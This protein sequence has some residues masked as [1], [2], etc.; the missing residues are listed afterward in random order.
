MNALQKLIDENFIV[1]T[2]PKI[3]TNIDKKGKE[4]KQPINMPKWK[5]ITKD[6]YLNYCNMSHQ[7][8]AIITGKISNLTILDFDDINEYNRLIKEYPE[9][10]TY[11]TIK[12]NKGVHMYFNYTDKLETTT[13]ALKS[14]NYVD[15]RNDDGVIFC[16][17][18]SYTLKNG[19]VCKYEDLGGNMLDVPD[20]LINDAKINIPSSPTSVTQLHTPRPIIE[21]KSQ[22]KDNLDFIRMAI[23]EGYLN[24]KALSNSYDDWRDVGFIFKHT[25]QSKECLQLFHEFSKLNIEKYDEEYTNKFWDT[26]KQTSNP[27][28]IAT[29]KMWVKGN[30]KICNTEV[31]ASNYLFDILKDS[32]KS[33]KGRL[34]YLYNR[35]WIYDET[36]IN[37]ILLNYIMNSNI[38]K[39]NEQTKKNVPYAQNVSN[40]EKIRKALISK[41][42]MENIDNDLYLKFHQSTKAKICFNDGV[43]DFKTKTFTLWENIPAN[44]IFTTTKINRN[45]NEYFNN[46]NREVINEITD[47]IFDS[48]FG[49]KLDKALHFLSR[50]LAGHSEDKRWAT[51]LGNRNC[52]KGVIYTLL[53]G[54]YEGYVSTFELGNLLYSRKTEGLENIDCSKKLYWLLDLEFVRLAVSQEIPDSSSGLK[55]NS[56]ML[57]R[58]TGGGDTI[59]ARRNYDRYDTYFT[60]DTSIFGMGNSQL[61]CDSKD[62]DET[63]IEFSSVV[64]FKTQAE[65]DYMKEQNRS[66]LEMKRYKVADADIKKK[67]ETLEWKNAVIYLI[68]ENYK[69]LCV[70]VIPEL[71]V[72]DNSLLGT[73]QEKFEFTYNNDDIIS[74]EVLHE[75]LGCFDKGKIK[76]EL[77]AMNIHKKKN[78]KQGLLKNKWCYYGIKAIEKEQ[79]QEE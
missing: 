35:V 18:T 22:E 40:A 9:L 72:E 11:R 29:L 7:A 3:I 21:N 65:I 48:L 30:V 17:P 26:I 78:Q 37:D 1:F 15:V 53:S 45:Y 56:K 79:K 28:T 5:E 67:C 23:K 39:Y 54:A 12:T 6:N 47:K 75:K 63:K 14:Y 51:Y 70:D 42:R 13:N 64:Q 31:E 10:K 27:L 66:D 57:K 43:L 33:Y 19:T 62:C 52:G 68:L 71:D 55:V 50:A 4:T 2:F 60:L 61:Q 49:D 76:L 20:F 8:S 41:I 59:V 69:N 25:S 77:N 44:T 74:C 24:S 32:F 34:F 58:I 73:L 46:P 36:T 38:Y 16:P